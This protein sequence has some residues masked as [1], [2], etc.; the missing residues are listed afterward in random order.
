MKIKYEKL[1]LELIIKERY[2]FFENKKQYDFIIKTLSE[3]LNRKISNIEKIYQATVDGDSTA[4]FHAKCV[5]HSNT[6]IIIKSTY[7]KIFGAF[8]SLAYHSLSGQYYY[9]TNAFIF[10]LII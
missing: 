6:L 5:G 9:D 7:N 8:T 3:R 4:N 2:P 10:L 1:N